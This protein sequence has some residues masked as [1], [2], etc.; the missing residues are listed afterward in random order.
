MLYG[1]YW[2]TISEG[3]VVQVPW[4]CGTW[5]CI[6][7]YK[8]HKKRYQN[9]TCSSSRVLCVQG[10][11]GW[12]LREAEEAAQERKMPESQCWERVPWCWAELSPRNRMQSSGK[13]LKILTYLDDLVQR[14]KQS[15]HVETQNGPVWSEITGT[16]FA[17]AGDTTTIGGLILWF[18]K[19][20][21]L[22][23]MKVS[24]VKAVERIGKPNTKP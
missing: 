22:F 12:T 16:G 13:C 6:M 8:G 14:S 18:Q 15:K 10:E 7:M 21:F 17:I 23:G 5:R 24:H 1:F 3:A 2:G 9:S 4:S 20:E 11:C 19:L